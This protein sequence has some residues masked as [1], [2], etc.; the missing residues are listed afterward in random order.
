LKAALTGL[1]WK[2]FRNVNAIPA[3]FTTASV[4]IVAHR[5]IFSDFDRF[6]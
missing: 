1:H 4:D 6:R 2:A 5:K 3:R